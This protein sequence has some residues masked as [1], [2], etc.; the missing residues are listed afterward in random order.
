[1]KEQENFPEEELNEMEGIQH[2]IKNIIHND[3]VGLILGRQGW[4]NI[5]RSINVIH[6]INKMKDTN[7]MIIPIDA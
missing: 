2:Y 6:Y 4:Y 5:H 3:Q 7:Y 1:M